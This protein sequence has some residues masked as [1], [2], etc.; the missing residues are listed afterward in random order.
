[1]ELCFVWGRQVIWKEKMKELRK[2]T[3][4]E[5]LV[6]IAIIAIL[7][8]M[9]LPA[10]NK[11]R[12][13]GH[14]ASCQ[15]NLKQLG[16]GLLGYAMDNRD[17]MV[18]ESDAKRHLGGEGEVVWSVFIRSYIGINQ[19][20]VADGIYITNLDAQYR[21]GILKCPAQNRLVRG[22]SYGHYGMPSYIGGHGNGGS[23]TVDKDAYQR[24]QHVL[25]P[26]KKAWLVDSIYPE[27]GRGSSSFD[28]EGGDLSSSTDA[29]WFRVMYGG[30]NLSRKRHGDS[31]NMVFVDG[32]VENMTLAEMKAVSNNGHW[33][34]EIFGQKGSTRNP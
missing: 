5:L 16:Q 11:S 20:T 21:N 31:S 26:S 24:T 9:L 10:L 1:M 30:A 34:S 14:I 19:Q 29:G 32:H 17:Y 28:K 18:P 23:Y 3:L 12:Q 27:K 6:V 4:I 22:F 15:G 33:N 25:R 7:A 8:G 13:K 2:F